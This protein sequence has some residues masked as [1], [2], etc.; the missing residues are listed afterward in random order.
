MKSPQ[1]FAFNAINLAFDAIDIVLNINRGSN[2]IK[3]WDSYK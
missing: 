3:S 2:Q 1:L